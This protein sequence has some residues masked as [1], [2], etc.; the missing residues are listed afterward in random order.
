MNTL[1]RL[2]PWSPDELPDPVERVAYL[3]GQLAGLRERLDEYRREWRA[4]AAENIRRHE[5][6]SSELRTN[7]TECA[8]QCYQVRAELLTAI[9]ALWSQIWRSAWALVGAQTIII[10][11]LISWLHGKV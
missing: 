3:E 11:A 9:A 5:L 8:D 4:D 6:H 2:P 1:I 7:R 10:G